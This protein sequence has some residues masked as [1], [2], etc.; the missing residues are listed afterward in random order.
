MA[1]QALEPRVELMLTELRLPSIRRAFRKIAKE[2]SSA[3]GDYVAYLLYLP[4]EPGLAEALSQLLA[5]TGRRT[6]PRSRKS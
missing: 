2:V 4:P 3:G 6:G 5:A 1:E